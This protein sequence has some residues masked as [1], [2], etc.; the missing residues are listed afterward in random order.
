LKIVLVLIGLY[1]STLCACG[2]AVRDV[3]NVSFRGNSTLPVMATP[4]F[5]LPSLVK[6]MQDDISCDG[7][8]NADISLAKNETQSFQIIIANKGEN[9]L[10]KIDLAVSG[11]QDGNSMYSPT[12]TLYREHYVNTKQSSGNSHKKVGAYPDA[13]IPFVDPYTGKEIVNAKYLARN[14]SIESHKNQGYWIDVYVDKNVKA[15]IYTNKISVLADGEI[16]QQ[17]PV[18]VRVWDFELPAVPPLKSWFNLVPDVSSYHNVSKTSSAYSTIEK[19]Y[20]M[21]LRQHGAVPAY[22][23]GPAVNSET[24]AVTFTPEYVKGLR[25]YIDQFQPGSTFLWL[26]FLGPPVRIAR[27]LSD[28]QKFVEQNPWIPE[29]F[30]LY[31]EPQTLDAY[32]KVKNCGAAMHKYA[33]SIKLMVTEQIEPQKEGWPSLEGYV[34]IWCPTWFLGNPDSIARRQQLGDKVWSYNALTHPE[35]V[36][37][38]L[39][40]FPLLDYRIPEWFS[41]TLDLEGILYWHTMSWAVSKPIVDPW[42]DSATCVIN[43]GK[44]NGEG[45][46]VY[47]GGAAGIDGPVASMRLKV[48]RDGVQDYDYLYL[49]SQFIGKDETKKI[50]SVVAKDFKTYSKNPNDYLNARKQL[51]DRILSEKANRGR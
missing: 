23:S 30:M 28:Y 46:L 15:G 24:G 17:I 14:Q 10:P 49:L 48:F 18:I 1:I 8:S 16:I 27:Y 7:N 34:D 13:L 45:S 50:S 19:R 26:S 44:W 38:W 9:P 47:P 39:I 37:T 29:P 12:I 41:F 43:T 42:T 20:M 32:Q 22:S 5:V 21:L 4:V 51:A 2:A 36:P 33:P 3:N 35:D 11:W 31:D 6:V 40:D 25:N